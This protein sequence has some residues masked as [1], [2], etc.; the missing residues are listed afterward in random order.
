[1][2]GEGES[3]AGP[4]DRPQPGG[5]GR[6]GGPGHPSATRLSRGKNNCEG[7]GGGGRNRPRGAHGAESRRRPGRA[8]ASAG[9]CPGGTCESLG[10]GTGDRPGTGSSTVRQ[11]GPGV[12]ARPRHV[13]AASPGQGRA[14]GHVAPSLSPCATST[15][16]VW[17]RRSRWVG[18]GCPATPP[19]HRVGL[20]RRPPRRRRNVPLERRVPRGHAVGVG[21]PSRA[22]AAAGVG[23]AATL[24][25]AAAGERLED[26]CNGAGAPRA[27]CG[28]R[29][30]PARP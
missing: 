21:G 17:H 16:T 10:G 20:A 26:P 24:V 12:K 30:G 6:G 3:A 9:W 2:G 18:R 29:R 19:Q 11:P 14:R 28:S 7:A 25:A 5:G 27:P 1:M 13:P 8:R 15:V 23:T 22:Q 4:G